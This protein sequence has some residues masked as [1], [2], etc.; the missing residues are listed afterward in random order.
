MQPITIEAFANGA[1]PQAVCKAQT[2]EEIMTIDGND[3]A[4][5]VVDFPFPRRLVVRGLDANA[6]GVTI[7]I[8]GT[9]DADSPQVEKF[10]INTMNVDVVGRLEFKT[11][12]EIT[13]N[14]G[15][16][17][18]AQIGTSG[19]VG[20]Q[21]ARLDTWALGP[22]NVQ[23]NSVGSANYTLQMTL[24]DPNDARDPMDPDEVRWV[25]APDTNVVNATGDKFTTFASPPVFLRLLINS[26]V[27]NVQATIVQTGSSR[28]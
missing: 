19:V 25:P 12:Q 18:T 16:V 1:D 14:I 28:F 20:S 2:I 22:T 7:T 8:T 23:I 6:E 17:G 11:V 9:D 3:A 24:D 13:S 10:R 27:G 4:D 26:G 21:W 15:G 5:G